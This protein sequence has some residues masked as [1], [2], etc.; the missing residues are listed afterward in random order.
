MCLLEE[1]LVVLT[2]VS[3]EHVVYL[4]VVGLHFGV[5]GKELRQGLLAFLEGCCLGLHFY[6]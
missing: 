6:A 5:V 4:Q 3:S 1:L 2:I